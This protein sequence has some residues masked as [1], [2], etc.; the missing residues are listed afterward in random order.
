[1]RLILAL[2]VVVLA[3]L[4]A[5]TAVG[6]TNEDQ[7]RELFKQGGAKFDEQAY[8]E[9]LEAF[10]QADE[11]NPSWK[12]AFNIGQCQA[13]LKRYGL[14]IEAFERYLAEGGDEVPDER[15]SKVL[16]ELSQF[17]KMVGG[18]MV[19]GEDDVVVVIDGITR[20]ST[21]MNQ[22]ILVTAGVKHNI[23]LVKQE[24]VLKTVTDTVRG[25]STLVIEVGGDE[26]AAPVPA[27]VDD[28]SDQP[29]EISEDD[30]GLSPV[31]FWVGLGAT[32][33]FA[34]GA[35]GTNFLIKDLKD[36]GVV[37]EEDWDQAKALRAT[38]LACFGLAVAAGITTGVLAFFTDW[39]GESPNELQV[40]AFGSGEGAGLTLQ[41]S[42]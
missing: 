34:G 21:P 15:R 41:R 39:D 40:G 10:E 29:D 1:M 24:E 36:D 12:I 8:E 23:E 9:A 4:A 11:L 13:A 33:V 19:E 35:V 28:T 16:D 32:V 27:P 30:G 6:Q 7:A 31:W 5:A 25:E 14:A 17:R 20:G 38:G 42:F 37:Y 26:P 3:T 22:P 18:V 2:S